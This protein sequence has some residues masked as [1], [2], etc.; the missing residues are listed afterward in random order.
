[1]L[2]VLGG[3]FV[4]MVVAF[5]VRPLTYFPTLIATMPLPKLF[6]IGYRNDVVLSGDYSD[7]S[8][9]GFSVSDLVLAAGI[10]VMIFQR[11]SA[12]TALTQRVSRALYW[13]MMSIALSVWIAV[14]FFSE[15]YKPA[16]LLYMVRYFMT[17][18]SYITAAHYARYFIH[19]YQVAKLLRYTVIT[20]VVVLALGVAYYFT[21]GSV[22]GGADEM[23]MG[24][25]A[26]D[27]NQSLVFRS[28]LWF[29]D[30]GNDM[31]FYAVFIGTLALVIQTRP[32]GR[33]LQA[34][35]RAVMLIAIVS[36]ILLN[37]RANLLVMA[38]AIAYLGWHFLSREAQDFG[39]IL[40]WIG[41]VVIGGVVTAGILYVVQPQI[42]TKVLASSGTELSFDAADYLQERGVPA[43]ISRTV[44]SLPIGD[45][46]MRFS[47]SVAS[48]W[49]FLQFPI[50]V[51]FWGELQV[52][53]LFAHHEVVKVLVE[54]SLPG[55]IA[56]FA[57]LLAVKRV[58]WNGPQINGVAADLN[59]VL[60]ANSFALA[61]ALIMANT[62]L[63]DFKFAVLYW[64]ML[65][66]FTT[67]QATFEMRHTP[68][69][70]RRG[71]ES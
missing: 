69:P 17:L 35:C 48:L 34:I 28:Y 2:S 27:A 61:G 39:V 11:R 3:A 30:Y 53:G 52:L 45:N 54:Q 71:L 14:I 12:P 58:L 40:K 9:P 56:Y 5:M 16:N 63:L 59:L 57:L 38:L 49:A 20:G 64:S 47:F 44:S 67:I 37:Q 25:N 68:M 7:S 8:D 31:G 23:R 22:R 66:L 36:I 21:V 15:S 29:F 62:V 60:R 18:V 19:Q 55:I 50:G 1:M 13:W 41:L 33:V 70:I 10:V 24:V 42:I 4:L 26:M 43:V 32:C 65:G 51:G 46:V 6:T